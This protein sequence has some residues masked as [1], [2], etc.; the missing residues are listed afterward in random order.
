M[1]SGFLI[2]PY[3]Q[4]RIFS[5]DEIEILI[6]SKLT[7]VACWLKRFMTSWFMIRS[8][9]TPAAPRRATAS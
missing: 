9:L 1:V 5:G 7:G 8:L 4:E 6:W 3:D 2:S